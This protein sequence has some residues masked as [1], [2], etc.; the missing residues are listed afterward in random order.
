VP[1]AIHVQLAG[2]ATQL[3][4]DHGRD[5]SFQEFTKTG[6][7]HNPTVV[8]GAV[9]VKKAVSIAE[10]RKQDGG[11]EK[12]EGGLVPHYDLEIIIDGAFE[13]TNTMKITDK[14]QVYQI[15]DIE[16]VEPGETICAYMV[17]AVI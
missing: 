15:E 8:P 3:I 17:S 7:S 11:Q 1:N 2:I 6:P 14:G 9:V 10:Y 4:N 13:P 5:M 16:P 12:H